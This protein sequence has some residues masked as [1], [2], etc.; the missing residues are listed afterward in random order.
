MPTTYR[1]ARLLIESGKAERVSCKP[2]TIQLLHGSTGYTQDITLGIDAGYQTIGFSAVTE[3]AELIGGEVEML[4]G[5][6][7]RNGDR[8][9]H[10]RNRRS[11]LRHRAPRFDNRRQPDGW[12]A[13]SIQHKLDTH[14]R[15]IERLCRVMPVTYIIIETANF[16]IQGIKN[17]GI[18]GVGYQTGEQT[19]FWNLR[20][21]VLHRDHHRCQN[22]D[23]KNKAKQPILQVHHLGYWQDDHSDRPGNLITLCTKCHTSA[24]HKK[25]KLLHGWRPKLKSYRPETFMSTV[26]W[27]LLNHFDA[28]NAY[29][30]QTKST[31]IKLG[32]KKSHHNDAFVIAYG[33]DQQ[34]AE[35]TTIKQRRRNNRSL[36]RFY[37]AKYID[38]R[39][40]KKA[41][42]QELSSGRRTRNRKFNGENLRLHRGHKTS[43]GTRSIR[44][45]RYALQPGD[46]GLL[47]DV[48]RIVNGTH[49]I[50]RRVMLY[51]PD[52]KK[53][54]I[55]IKS[56]MPLKMQ[57]G[58][59]F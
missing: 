1:K 52:G 3:T 11:R 8:A 46:I 51:M 29:G 57:N 53:G 13:P 42:G 33:T 32:L 35:T 4:K 38:L 55:S 7:A 58:L 17:P 26:R 44:Q 34:R 31:R 54:S 59:V 37:D 23:C 20:E 10:R 18:E 14:I 27:R 47:N 48:K 16:D 56:V 9:M 45:Q 2:D 28:I 36:E 5:Q 43:K 41:S 24:N 50:G 49:C 39:T 25:G 30:Y 15:L 22:P 19:G 12:L 21:Y 40:G 6:K